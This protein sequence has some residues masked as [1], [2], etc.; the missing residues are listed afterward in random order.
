MQTTRE[1]EK[2]AI[3]ACRL[4]I[5]HMSP[6]PLHSALVPLGILHHVSF[7]QAVSGMRRGSGWTRDTVIP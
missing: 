2:V 3:T 7:C 4:R 1:M 5:S 6:A